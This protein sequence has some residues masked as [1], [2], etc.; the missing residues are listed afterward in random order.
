M[1][2]TILESVLN[3]ISYLLIHTTMEKEA[4]AAGGVTCKVGLTLSNFL[5][6][7]PNFLCEVKGEVIY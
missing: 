7:S 4:M 5:P 2:I 3:G 6:E 1:M